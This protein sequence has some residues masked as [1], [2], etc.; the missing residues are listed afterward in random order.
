MKL[1]IVT[2]NRESIDL[3]KTVCHKYDGV[4]FTME[5]YVKPGLIPLKGGLKKNIEGILNSYD[6][7]VFIM[8]MG[9]IVREIAP[10]IKHKSID[11][12]ILCLSIDGEYIIPVLSGHL[13]GANEFALE[14]EKRVGVKAIITTTSDLLN[15]KAVDMIA[16]DNNLVIDNFKDAMD[17]TALMIDK[18]D[19]LVLSD[20]EIEI[21][22]LE[23]V[24]E[25]QIDKDT[26]GI[27][28]ISYKTDKTFS[29]PSA[30]LIPKR[31]VV[32]IGAKRG[33]D[34]KTISNLLDRELKLHFLDIRAVNK[35]TSIDLKEDE[36]GIIE[37]SR[38]LKVPFITY[39]CS[40]LN[41]VVELF[42]QS[43]FVKKI[44]GVGA[45]SMPSGYLGSNRGECLVNKVV[46]DGVTL[47]IWEERA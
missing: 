47:S 5:R 27:I 44:T 6:V 25:S 37:L 31:L 23:I 18:K 22:D 28:N 12:A 46:E 8:A 29:I 16:K 3:A 9:I 30:R 35:I 10:Y 21:D 26:A 11:P 43:D 24:R 15:C 17:I 13:G 4:I 19:I 7:V 38:E 42:D 1:A 33:S 40:E 41:S 39:S 36:V 32:G 14:F 2:L 20:R 45:V 34:F